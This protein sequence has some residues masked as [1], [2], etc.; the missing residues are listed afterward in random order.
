MLIRERVTLNL[1]DPSRPDII[2]ESLDLWVLASLNH[3]LL[4][5]T[6]VSWINSHP[7]CFLQLL[8]NPSLPLLWTS[9]PSPTPSFR[10]NCLFRNFEIKGPADR[11]LIYLILFI[12]D[13]ITHVAS[14][15]GKPSPSYGEAVKSLQ[16][17]SV[18]HFSLP[19][20]VGFP[21]N[22]LFKGPKDRMEGG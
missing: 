7:Q 20:E 6:V 8:L 14:K 15:P 22:S 17:L 18:D 13:C 12:S 9:L 19:G 2:E 16:T 10:A 21:L 11:L 5:Y 1:E 3:R 4:S